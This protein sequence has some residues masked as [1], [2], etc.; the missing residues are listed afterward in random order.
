MRNSVQQVID[1]RFYTATVWYFFGIAFGAKPETVKAKAIAAGLEPTGDTFL[2]KPQFLGA[3]IVGVEVKNSPTSVKG[4]KHL[5]GTFTCY[6]QASEKQTS[7]ALFKELKGE[8]YLV[9]NQNGFVSLI[10]NQS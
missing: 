8:K 2:F 9:E 6:P 3:S 10:K 5:K 1:A 4:I 7:I